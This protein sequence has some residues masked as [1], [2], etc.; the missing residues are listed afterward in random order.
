VANEELGSSVSFN[1]VLRTVRSSFGTA[2]SGAVLAANMGMIF[3]PP[4]PE[5][6]QRLHSALFFVLWCSS[7]CS[8]TPWLRITAR[9]LTGA[10]VLWSTKRAH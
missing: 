6:L 7:R 4:G 5:S 1:Q 2:I 3:T 8:S 10:E 9:P